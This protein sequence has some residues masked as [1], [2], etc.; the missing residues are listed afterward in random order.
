MSAGACSPTATSATFVTAREFARNELVE[1]LDCRL[2]RSGRSSYVTPIIS[3]VG[4]EGTAAA[5]SSVTDEAVLGN[6]TLPASSPSSAV[7]Q[8]TESPPKP[9]PM[10]T[11]NDAWPSLPTSSPVSSVKEEP[12]SV[13]VV[14]DEVPAAAPPEAMTTSNDVVPSPPVPP[15]PA[16]EPLPDSSVESLVEELVDVNERRK[17][18]TLVLVILGSVIV[19]FLM[20]L[21]VTFACN[22]LKKRNDLFVSNATYKDEKDKEDF[23]EEHV[24]SMA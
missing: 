1:G 24:G 22:R 14:V 12:V 7:T 23:C 16:R 9:K 3:G 6:N 11:S 10:G 21:R 19:V 4:E 20:I 18:I 2:C 15:P 8:P 17:T 5:A 13:V